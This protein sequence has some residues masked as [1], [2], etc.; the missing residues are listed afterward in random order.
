MDPDAI[1]DL[2]Q[3]LGPIRLRRL[4][5]GRGIYRDDLMFA[6]EARGEIYLK[7]DA[8]TVA[9]FEA[10]GSRPFRF[11]KAGTTH[12][13]S[14]WLLPAEAADDPGEAA[15]WGQLALEAARRSR[16]RKG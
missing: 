16:S 15:A 9:R 2:F 10:A 7:T 14:Y 3:D 11:S 12:A 5:G 8:G 13:T 1:R 6:L 4:F